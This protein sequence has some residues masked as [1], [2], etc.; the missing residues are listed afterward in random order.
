MSKVYLVTGG[1]GFVGSRLCSA[2]M[3]TNNCLHMLVRKENTKIK[4]KQFICDFEKDDVP[5]LSM[6]GVDTVFHLAGYTHDLRYSDSVEN[7]YYDINVKA[8]IQLA[9]LAVKKGVKRFVFVSS[10]KAGGKAKKQTCMTE[11]MQSEPEGLYGETKRLAEIKLLEI[12]VETGMHVSIVRPSLIYGAGVKGN[13]RN[14]INGIDR[15]WFPRISNTGNRRSMV[16]VDDVVEALLLVSNDSRANGEIFIVT[17]GMEYST[18][19]V[20]D[21]IRD[22]IGGKRVTWRL[23]VCFFRLLA[24]IGDFFQ[25]KISFPFDSHRYQKLLGDELFSSKKLE[26]KIGYKAQCSFYSALP[27]IVKHLRSELH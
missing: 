5:E 6:D 24:K 3:S 11:S 12:G 16:C 2:I 7:R 8:T 14:M 15:G 18:S 25:G 23:P 17:D 20:Y 10:T 19:E 26:K 13:L 22:E 1:T 9:E 4:A 21:A 27:S